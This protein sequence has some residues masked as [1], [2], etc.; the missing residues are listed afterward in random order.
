MRR[1]TQL[2]ALLSLSAA[3]GFA[4]SL[5]GILV[6]AKCYG[7]EERNVNP[8]DTLTNVDRDRNLEIRFCHPRAKTKLF[9]VVT[10]DGLSHKLDSVGNMKAAELVRTSGKKSHL[11]VNVAG[12]TNKD[13]IRVDSISLV[14]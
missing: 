14:D 2:L 7:S 11:E 6:D 13:T 10:E 8:T 9:A 5:S 1:T 12:E 4:E 3:L